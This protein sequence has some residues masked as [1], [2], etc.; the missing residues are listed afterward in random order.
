MRKRH[1]PRTLNAF[2]FS[3]LLSIGVMFC[4]VFFPFLSKSK[5]GNSIKKYPSY[6]NAP[7]EE[8][9]IGLT[10][11]EDANQ[12]IVQE[13]GGRLR[14]W[15][16]KNSRIVHEF[17]P[18]F[19]HHKA[20]IADHVAVCFLSPNRLVS[21]FSGK[22]TVWDIERGKQI[23]G[24]SRHIDEAIIQVNYWMWTTHDHLMDTNPSVHALSR[25]GR[26]W[27]VMRP[28]VA[29]HSENVLDGE[30]GIPLEKRR[31]LM[32]IEVHQTVKSNVENRRAGKP[33]A[34]WIFPSN[35]DYSFGGMTDQSPIVL[36]D[37]GAYVAIISRLAVFVYDNLGNQVA[38]LSP[39][40]DTGFKSSYQCMQFGTDE[41]IALASGSGFVVVYNWK[42]GRHWETII[43][44][45]NQVKSLAIRHKYVAVGDSGK[46][47][48][49]EIFK[50]NLLIKDYHVESSD[51]V[52]N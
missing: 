41:Q 18:H 43:P 23:Y 30:K 22:S 15:D 7:P 2:E 40:I 49:L 9:V 35:P 20:N 36:S 34:K 42:T 52:K 27:V 13:A 39:P 16:V 25:D 4:F 48:V 51:E 24:G 46:F 19:A 45:F 32:S 26:I 33:I 28:T 5:L 31:D 44:E 14:S 11:T 12:L 29:S 17:G 38:H 50:D 37:T 6:K 21:T 10:F 8:H 1:S 47:A 3:V